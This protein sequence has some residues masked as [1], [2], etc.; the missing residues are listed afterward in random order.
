MLAQVLCV[1]LAERNLFTAL[2]DR[3]ANLLVTVAVLRHLT[4]RSRGGVSS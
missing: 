1:D 3:D 2:G 4:S